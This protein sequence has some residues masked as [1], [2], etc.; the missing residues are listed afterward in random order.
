MRCYLE[1]RTRTVRDMTADEAALNV[2]GTYNIRLIH[3]T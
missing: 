3:S 2:A 1:I